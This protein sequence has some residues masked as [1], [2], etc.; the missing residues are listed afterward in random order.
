M[1]QSNMKSML[2]NTRKAGTASNIKFVI[3][4]VKLSFAELNCHKIDYHSGFIL[5]RNEAH[6]TSKTFVELRTEIK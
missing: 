6:R 5:L 3:F 1:I 2:M 4:F